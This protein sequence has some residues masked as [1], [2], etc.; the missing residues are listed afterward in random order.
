M[1]HDLTYMDCWRLIAPL[2]PNTIDYGQV[3]VMTFL[4]LQEAEKRRIADAN[5][6]KCE[7]KS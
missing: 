4:A 1:N 3:F 7:K 5:G 6:E 2:I